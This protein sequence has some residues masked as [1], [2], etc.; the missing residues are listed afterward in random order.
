M[1]SDRLREAGRPPLDIDVDELIAAALPPAVVST[2]YRL[3]QSVA[4]PAE[5]D[6]VS[7][8][9]R[10]DGGTVVIDIVGGAPLADVPVWTAKARAL[11]G[12]FSA[13]DARLRLAVPACPLL[14]GPRPKA[15]L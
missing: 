7:V 10:R 9:L 2:A 3:V 6:P 13:T 1:L 5:G 8:T 15:H 14:P 11:G 4:L 12:T